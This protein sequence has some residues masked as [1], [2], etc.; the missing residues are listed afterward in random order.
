MSSITIG[1]EINKFFE[2]VYHLF[3]DSIMIPEYL[4]LDDQ[5]IQDTIIKFMDS[6]KIEGEWDM[7]DEDREGFGT[8][9]FEAGYHD[10]NAVYYPFEDTNDIN[11]FAFNELS[12]VWESALECIVEKCDNEEQVNEA[13]NLLKQLDDITNRILNL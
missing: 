12:D 3:E 10:S 4:N 11:K 9:Y 1:K 5:Y 13:E 7:T 8:V 6:C 2:Q